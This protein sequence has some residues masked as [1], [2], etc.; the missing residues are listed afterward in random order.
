[1]NLEFEQAKFEWEHLK[2]TLQRYDDSKLALRKN[3]LAELYKNIELADKLKNRLCLHDHCKPFARDD[4]YTDEYGSGKST[5]YLGI[6]CQDCEQ[7]VLNSEGNQRYNRRSFDATC[8]SP[9]IQWASWWESNRYSH[10]VNGYLK[11]PYELSEVG[12][13]VITEI[14]K[15]YKLVDVPFRNYVRG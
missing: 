14:K 5:Y 8:T 13:K 1:M 9:L 6:L 10:R 7:I 2:L 3:K 11:Y 12:I 15:E 4:Y